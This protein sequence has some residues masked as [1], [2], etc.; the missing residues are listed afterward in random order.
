MKHCGKDWTECAVRAI[1]DDLLDLRGISDQWWEIDCD[2]RDEIIER[3]RHIIAE[4]APEVK[5]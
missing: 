5:P 1:V 4:Y 2:T 3:W